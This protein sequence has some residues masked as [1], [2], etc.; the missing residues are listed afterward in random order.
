MMSKTKIEEK[1]AGELKKYY[2]MEKEAQERDL[3][4]CNVNFIS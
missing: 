1:V 3:K 2:I 4:Y